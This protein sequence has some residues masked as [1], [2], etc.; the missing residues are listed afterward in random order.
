MTVASARDVGVTH[1]SG[2]RAAAALARPTA[3]AAVV[4]VY[5]AT[6][7]AVYTGLIS[8]PFAYAGYTVVPQPWQD[9]VL[10]TLVAVVVALLLPARITRASDI[11]LWMLFGVCVAPAILMPGYTGYLTSIEAMRFALLLATAF[12]AAA[13]AVGWGGDRVGSEDLQQ[14]PAVDG[15]GTALDT[16][17]I[18]SRVVDRNALAWVLCA[19]YSAATYGVMAVTTGFSLHFVALDDVYDVRA[20]YADDLSAGGPLGYLLSGQAYVVNVYVLIRAFARRTWP[21]VVLALLGQFVIY[22]TTGFKTVLFSI[23]AMVAIAVVLRR[24]RPRSGAPLLLGPVLLMLVSAGVD[25]LQG[26]ITWTSLFS[27]RFIVTP[28]L[29]TSVY[30]DYFSDHPV[31]LWAKSFTRL[32]VTSPY[33]VTPTKTIGQ[34]MLPGSQVNANANLF[35]DGYANL[36]TVGLFVIAAVLAVWLRCLDRWSRGVP[37]SVVGVL[38]VM[39]AVTLS[40]TSILTAMLSHGLLVG[41]VLVAVMPRRGWRWFDRDAGEG[42]PA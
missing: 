38:V 36:G 42:P 8:G 5:A 23:P 22:T 25:L 40:N 3:L 6:L 2:F 32:W 29:L 19:V 20:A 28:G 17:R 15:G 27:R 37:A 4:V 24:R 14:A 41:T 10:A 34:Y 35:A 12:A 26:S 39:S 33:D 13:V 21:L 30:A 7:H 18:G 11:V 9:Q 31:A 1:A 16:V